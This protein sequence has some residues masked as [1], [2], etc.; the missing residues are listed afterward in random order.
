MIR[1]YDLYKFKYQL[2]FTILGRIQ[3]FIYSLRRNTSL[4]ERPHSINESLN[5]NILQADFVES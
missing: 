4:Y 1:M 2:P 5:S 3:K